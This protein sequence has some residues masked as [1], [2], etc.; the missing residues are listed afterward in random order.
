MGIV[1]HRKSPNDYAT[2]RPEHFVR[3][4]LTEPGNLPALKQQWLSALDEAKR[5][6]DSRPPNELACLYYSANLKKFVAPAAERSR[7][8]ESIVPHYGRPGGILPKI[9]S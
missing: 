7:T 4:S 2:N 9:L 3:L 1:V 5:F 8:D 6:I